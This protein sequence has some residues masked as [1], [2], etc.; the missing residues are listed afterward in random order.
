[1]PKLTLLVVLHGDRVP[2]ERLIR[3]SRGRFDELL[4]IHD[5]PDTEDVRSVVLGEGG[6]FFERPR[7]YSQEPHFPFGFEHASHDWILRLDSDEYPSAEMKAWLEDF[8][9]SDEPPDDV[10]SFQCIWPA[11][12]GTKAI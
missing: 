1:M 11:W 4:V 7:T 9:K 8:R 12:D 2:L 5:G 10:A 6:R 3:E